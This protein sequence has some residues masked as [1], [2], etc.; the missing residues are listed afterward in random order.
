M[1]AGVIEYG[2]AA[3]ALKKRNGAG[4][5]SRAI[6]PMINN[7]ATLVFDQRIN[8]RVFVIRLISAFRCAICLLTAGIAFSGYRMRRFTAFLDPWSNCQDSAF[9]LCQSLIAFGSGGVGGS[10]GP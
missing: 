1:T 5:S 8:V 3:P 2:V 7:I 10:G 4:R 6:V 9:Q